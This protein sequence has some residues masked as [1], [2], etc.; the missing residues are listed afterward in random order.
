VDRT[1]TSLRADIQPCWA[2]VPQS[3][4]G[5]EKV[6]TLQNVAHNIVHRKQYPLE[7]LVI[8]HEDA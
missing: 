4:L 7:A 8:M 5:S 6:N 1:E 3:A 2:D